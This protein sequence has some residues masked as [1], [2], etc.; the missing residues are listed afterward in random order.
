MWAAVRYLVSLSPAAPHAATIQRHA[1]WILAADPEAGL[2]AFLHMRPPLDPSLALSILER[3]SRHYCGLYLETALQI[4]VALPQVRGRSD[5]G[6]PCNIHML[7]SY[8]YGRWSFRAIR[9]G[10][11]GTYM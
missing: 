10:Y 1:G 7:K 5:E 6:S 3:H 11:L 4:G 2:S 9:E 8:A